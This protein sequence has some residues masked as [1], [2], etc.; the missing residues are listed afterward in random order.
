MLLDRIE[1]DSC[2]SLERIQL[3]PFSHRLNAIYGPRG[4]GKTATL[5]FL[6]GVMLG[7]DREWHRGST[8]SVVW[9]DHEGLLHCR[10]ERDGTLAGRLSIDYVARD[11]RMHDHHYGYRDPRNYDRLDRMTE[12]PRQTIDGIVAATRQTPLPAILDACR[13]AGLETFSSID[14]A[15]SIARLRETIATLERQLNARQFGGDPFHNGSLGEGYREYPGT[16]TELEALRVRLLAELEEIARMERTPVRHNQRREELTAR[17]LEAHDEVSRLGHQESELRQLIAEIERD[18]ANT[19][20]IPRVENSN[21][22]IAT[23]QRRELEELDNQLMRWRRTLREICSIRNSLADLWKHPVITGSDSEPIPKG[24]QDPHYHNSHVQRAGEQEPNVS[25]ARPTLGRRREI[26]SRDARHKSYRYRA[27]Q[28][29]DLRYLSARSS[30][31]PHYDS[32]DSDNPAVPAADS[33]A[34]PRPLHSRLESVGR[35]IEILVQRYESPTVEESF[36]VERKADGLSSSSADSAA[37]KTWGESLRVMRNELSQSGRQLCD[38]QLTASSEAQHQQ[39]RHC[40]ELLVRFIDR[41]IDVRNLFLRRIASE[42]DMPLAQLVDAFGD[43][44]Q[45]HDHP[46]L[47]QWLLSDKCPPRLDDVA[48]HASRRKR[49][50]QEQAE[51]L[52]QLGRTVNRLDDCANEI[53]VLQIRLRESLVVQP[54]LVDTRRRDA[55]RSE[56]VRVE[57]RLRWL[58][59]QVTLE[60]ERHRHQ[61]HL[62]ELVAGSTRPSM[63]MAAASRWLSQLGPQS[64]SRL[65]TEADGTLRVD[66]LSLA[67]LGEVD[68][69]TVAMAIRMAAAEEL[70]RRGHQVPLLID[71]PVTAHPTPDAPARLAAALARYSEGGRQMIVLTE[72][73]RLADAI[74]NL[75]G[76]VQSLA[77]PKYIQMRY[78][79]TSTSFAA[80]NPLA[81]VN[82]DLD[83]IWREA[84]GLYDDPFWY[85]T[86]H[87]SQSGNRRR[88]DQPASEGGQSDRA[89]RGPASPFFLTDDSPIDQAPSIDAVAANW[90]AQIGIVRVGQLLAADPRSLAERL[91]LSDVTPRLVRRWQGEAQLVCTVPQLRNFDARVLFGCG[92]T[93]AKQLAQMH[94]GQLLEKVEAFLA[95][96]QGRRILQSGTSYELSRITS[97]IAAANRSVARGLRHGERGP[98]NAKAPVENNASPSLYNPCS[99]DEEE[100][101]GGETNQPTAR[102]RR[103]K[104]AA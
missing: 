46:H 73:R 101:P 64:G 59:S 40:Q 104:R 43:W 5:E 44:R 16:R 93:D 102:R 45:C 22:P 90:L 83:M 51:L 92:F 7:T 94:P 47:Y 71:D 98:R 41:L 32:Q 55:C 34:V 27:A 10:R 89:S 26:R 35:Q 49:L 103:R 91:E 72:D 4:A 1:I 21:W 77:T 99:I 24:F 39:L 58:D 61:R 78:R 68:R 86:P 65:W 13:A 62:D 95:T 63:L 2:G 82:R 30:N 14:N 76:R 67:R 97:W 96:E 85:Q 6:R 9:A 42:Y 37:V 29:S 25:E 18:L 36:S 69:Q 60:E 54:S 20:E 66:G 19:G 70:S 79:D 17:L 11:G 23:A 15:A 56:L 57:E 52:E 53:R 33:R 100:I 87:R 84:N 3:G 8:G 74:R 12:L 31:A 81:D 48:V 28:Y 75:G 88:S 80:E 50:E 38:P